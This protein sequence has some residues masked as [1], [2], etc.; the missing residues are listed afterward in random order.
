MTAAIK[1]N[2]KLS[3]E[4]RIS[5]LIRERTGVH[6][7]AR[8]HAMIESRLRVRIHA[9]K[10]STLEEYVNHLEKHIHEE[11]TDL[12]SLLTTHH[13]YFF[14]EYSQFEFL[15]QKMPDLV[16]E[17][18]SRS[19]K[20]IRLWS[21]ACSRGQEVYSLA[22]F[23]DFHLKAF[24]PN[25]GVG[26]HILATDVDGESVKIARNGV[27]QRKEL[28]EAP[29]NFL[30]NH[31]SRGTGD[32]ADYVKAKTT[33]RDN[34]EFMSGNLLELPSEVRN[35]SFDVIF[36]RNVFIYFQPHVIEDVVKNLSGRLNQ[37]GMLFIGLS[38][39]LNGIKIPLTSL[40]NSVFSKSSSVGVTVAPTNTSPSTRETAAP[41]KVAPVAPVSAAPARDIRVL[42]VDDSPSIIA[43][44][45][46]ILVKN[47][48]FE[49]VGV[50]A[51]GQEAEKMV[52]E[53]KPDVMTLDIHMPV[54]TG[55]EYMRKNFSKATHPPVIMVTSV[56]RDDATLAGEA[57]SLGASDFVE[58][59]SLED[60]QKKSE[61]IRSKLKSA[62]QYKEMSVAAASIDRAFQ[63]SIAIRS[64]EHKLRIYISG[65]ASRDALAHSLRELRE[66]E[67][68]TFLLM[69]CLPE[70]LTVFASE[71]AK[72]SGK[73][74]DIVDSI[75]AVLET[76][77][78]YLASAKDLF[79]KLKHVYQLRPT[80]ILL[81]GDLNGLEL[82]DWPKAQWL[83]EDQIQTPHL[84][85]KAT[86]IVPLT[87]F[88]YMSMEY[89]SRFP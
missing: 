51:N 45:K 88:A 9:L 7:E 74:V 26:Y 16:K 20:K 11:L 25:S 78:V 58:K 77:R 40:G 4:E 39:N 42:C 81:L 43:L 85:A 32:I 76:N 19:D 2:G 49:V 55:I 22:M 69:N 1:Q 15:A 8:H 59:P 5:N 84:R 86:D 30:A 70:M 53:L 54:M 72:N 82:T 87:S 23:L 24:Y 12:I 47:A 48:G 80:S 28:A 10:L 41:A 63:K 73:T 33:L 56:S 14:R 64:P 21:A 61:E 89:L 29:L 6:L 83:I 38:E 71:I 35:R 36:C 65:I 52:K 31:W 50:A 60:M 34:L 68:P 37:T 46:K 79:S 17:A 62:F 18:S 75:P 13:T 67:P 27:Y 66:N 44:L 57:L 3:A